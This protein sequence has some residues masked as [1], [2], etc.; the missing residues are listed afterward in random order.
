MDLKK[1]GRFIFELR[2]EKGLTQ[3]QLA[4]KLFVTDKAISKWE[5]GKGMPDSSI[6]IPL[7]EILGV[8]ASEILCGER[9]SE[10]DFVEKSN[11]VIVEALQVTPKKPINIV[12]GLIIIAISIVLIYALQTPVRMVDEYVSQTFN[13][14]NGF[15]FKCLI[16]ICRGVLIGGIVFGIITVADI[17]KH[18]IS[19]TRSGIRKWIILV[20]LLLC[21]LPFWLFSN[22]F[23]FGY[24]MIM[25]LFNTAMVLQHMFGCYVFLLVLYAIK[26]RRS[27]HFQN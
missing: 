1:I 19:A 27:S 9:I 3:K 4:E 24:N 8:T 16:N 6:L 5:N 25:F 7:A 13:A 26:T 22:P 14:I 18:V 12:A 23:G 2:N 15:Y 21:A 11:N 20:V 17:D 10:S